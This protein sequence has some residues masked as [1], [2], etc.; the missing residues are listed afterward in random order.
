MAFVVLIASTK[1]TKSISPPTVG[2]ATR[3]I[4]MTVVISSKV[5]VP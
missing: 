4:L 1:A 5:D 3:V 2:K